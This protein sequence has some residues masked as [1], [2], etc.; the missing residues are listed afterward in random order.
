MMKRHLKTYVALDRSSSLAPSPTVAAGLKANDAFIFPK[1]KPATKDP[2]FVR[3][4]N[5]PKNTPW[6]QKTT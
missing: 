4:E 5:I 2:L 3:L 6:A 1:S